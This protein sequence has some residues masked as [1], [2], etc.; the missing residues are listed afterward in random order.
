MRLLRT[1]NADFGGYRD[2]T[3]V[4]ARVAQLA[5]S[6]DV[7]KTLRREDDL[8]AK[9]LAWAR[10]YFDFVFTLRTSDP[11]Q[12]VADGKR[13]ASVDEIVKLAGNTSDSLGQVAARR[14]INRILVYST[15]YELRGYEQSR[16]WEPARTL[17]QVAEAV[18]PKDGNVCYA[19]AQTEAQLLKPKEAFSHL[20]CAE[21]SGGLTRDALRRDPLFA[22]IRDDPRF[23]VIEGR[24]TR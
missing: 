20:E 2:T 6:E 7:R 10:G 15:F 9:D 22:P 21:R 14:A 5:A 1:W 24:L 17:L 18:A 12:S 11:G 4:A 3:E 16:R 13:K 8:E 23:V 19:L